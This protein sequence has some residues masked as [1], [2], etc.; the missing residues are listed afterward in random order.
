MIVRAPL[1]SLLCG[2]CA[3]AAFAAN[4][5][6]FEDNVVVPLPHGLNRGITGDIEQ[7]KDEALLFVY[8][9][10]A[11][12]VGR[13]STD[14]G[15]TWGDEFSVYTPAKPPTIA[16]PSLLRMDNGEIL[17]SYLVLYNSGDCHQ[18][19][20]IS[21]DECKTWGPAICSTPYPGYHT[22][23]N[24]RLVQLK[25]GRIISPVDWCEDY[26]KEW[27]FRAVCFYSDDRARTWRRGGVVDL[28][29]T[30]EEPGVVELKDRR[31]LEIIRSE[32]GYVG[33]AYSSDQGIT[34]TKPEMIK[35]LPAPRGPATIVRVPKTGE[36][37]IFFLYNQKIEEGSERKR[38][39]LA[40]AI[41]TDEGETWTHFRTELG[42]DPE[43][44]YGYVGCTFIGDTALVNFHSTDGIHVARVGVD[45]FCGK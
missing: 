21:S 26:N 30:T 44:D 34:W 39:P 38:A 37:L 31:L 6:L 7:L 25:S 9:T 16:S 35:Q 33:K 29:T 11:G 22:G 15:K 14:M 13:K 19:V 12:I 1:S 17:L 4:E 18:Y 8:Q 28:G 36:L 41:S 5:P 10:G 24:D 27:H 32:G 2:L 23:N 3:W 43:G 45:W 20:Q 42:P 40:T